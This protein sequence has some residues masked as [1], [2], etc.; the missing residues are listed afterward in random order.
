MF[1]GK[2]K[3]SISNM[4]LYI[5][6]R[7]M[8]V[9]KILIGHKVVSLKCS[10]LRR[11]Y[12]E[13]FHEWKLIPLHYVKTYLGKDFKFYSNVKIPNKILDKEILG[14]WGTYYFQAPT[15]PSAIGSQY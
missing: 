1:Y 12:N 14:W 3:N 10:W 13:N 6:I 15:V 8:M 4:I 5:T 7:K 9:R 11:L 2:T